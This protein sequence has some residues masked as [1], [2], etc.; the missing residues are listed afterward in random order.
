MSDY[1]TISY[2]GR[3]L[4]PPAGLLAAQWRRLGWG[5]RGWRL[6]PLPSC[7]PTAY[8]WRRQR[9]AEIAP[10]WRGVDDRNTLTEESNDDE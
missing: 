7:W 8:S 6:T 1:Q 4:P 10:C 3:R 2:R 5:S 9:L